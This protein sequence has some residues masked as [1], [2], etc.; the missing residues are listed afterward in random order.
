LV[1]RNLAKV[2]VAGSSPVFRSGT[3][4]RAGRSRLHL[5]DGGTEVSG[6]GRATGR[7]GR[8]VRRGS[9]KPVTP[10]QF[11]ASP[12]VEARS[13]ER[14]VDRIRALSSEGERFLDTEEVRGSIPLGPTETGRSEYVR[15]GRPIGRPLL[16]LESVGVNSV[17]AEHALELVGHA[18][19]RIAD[20]VGVAREEAVDL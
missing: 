17:S 16:T 14:A 15:R 11:R 12:R 9:A 1:E 10:V 18:T 7:R 8:V 13:H 19:H 5:L 4:H 20:T 3:G 6:T 2:E